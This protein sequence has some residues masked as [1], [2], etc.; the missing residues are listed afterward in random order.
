MTMSRGR[1]LDS[2]VAA[3]RVP[4]STGRDLLG[5]NHAGVVQRFVP[6]VGNEVED[7]LDRPTDDDAPSILTMTILLSRRG[8]GAPP[9]HR[10]KIH[11]RADDQI[12]WSRAAGTCVTRRRRR[13]SRR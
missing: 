9:H 13:A 11:S 2:M 7:V 4:L 10:V 1:P 6:F 12:R 5:S 3:Q 8:R